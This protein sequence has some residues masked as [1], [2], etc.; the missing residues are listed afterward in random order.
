MFGIKHFLYSRVKNDHNLLSIPK[1]WFAKRSVCSPYFMLPT[2]DL[3]VVG[4]FQFLKEVYMRSNYLD[5][6]LH[7]SHVIFIVLLMVVSCSENEKPTEPAAQEPVV[8]TNS[9][10]EITGTSAQCGGTVSSDGGA[11]VTARGVCWSTHQTPTT[12]DNKTTDSS[13]T[14]IFISSLAGL[15]P[16]TTYYVRAYATN[17]AGTGYGGEVSFG[18][19]G[20]VT[21]VDGNVYVAV[22]IGTQWWMKEN[23]KVAHYRNGDPI[24][25]VS[26]PVAW[27]SLNSGALC[28]YDNELD[29]VSTYGRLYNWFAIG[30]IRNVA[31]AGWHVATDAEWQTL[32]D[33]LGGS[34]TAGGKLKDTGTV[35]WTSPNTG[36][37]NESD[38]TGLPSGYRGGQGSYSGIGFGTGFWTAT[39]HEFIT[40]AAWNRNLTYNRQDIVHDYSGKKSGN[41]VRCVRD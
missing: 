23:L 5:S 2:I 31:P 26:D 28:E 40:D 29:N 10:A 36:A 30:D 18:T 27:N 33:F 39:G 34:E 15:T 8:L 19:N 16:S 1:N 35:H 24:P 7:Y 20:T 14:G 41:P 25:E 38:F 6:S 4:L 13:G 12:A 9:V 11:V 17:S 32:V 3:A 22:K 21:D 37:T